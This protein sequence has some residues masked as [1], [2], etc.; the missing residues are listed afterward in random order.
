MQDVHKQVEEV[1][2]NL[3]S[4]GLRE[5]HREMVK[6]RKCTKSRRFEEIG[7]PPELRNG[8]AE[9]EAEPHPVLKEGEDNL[10]GHDDRGDEAWN[11][12]VSFDGS[13]LLMKD[14]HSGLK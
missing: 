5:V 14:T 2:D 9:R 12:Q 11:N 7:K 10:L 3:H 4:C 13:D 1:I 8:H 6:E